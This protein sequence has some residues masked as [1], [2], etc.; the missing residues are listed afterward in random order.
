[1]AYEVP[2][3]AIC[4]VSV[5]QEEY[6]TAALLAAR[7]TGSLRG[8]PAAIMTAGALLILGVASI[9]WFGGYGIPWILP[10]I[11]IA[12]CPLILLVFLWA[13]PQALRRQARLDFASYNALMCPSHMALYADNIVTETPVMTLT[14]QY[15]LMAELVETPDLLVFIKDR[16]RML[17][18]PKRCLPENSRE[19]VL[20][21]M[22]LT[23]IRNRRVMKSW[24]A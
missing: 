17:I 14:D 8:I 9:T 20:E 22:R 19:A 4:Q 10:L 5:S 15:A 11:L 6:V 3:K 24:L 7:R 1:M 12:A 2:P 16:D 23:F 18:L 13:E 21:Q